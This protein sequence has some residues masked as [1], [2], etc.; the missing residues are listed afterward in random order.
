ASFALA[1]IFPE[2]LASNFG[3]PFDAIPKGHLSK[4]LYTFAEIMPFLIGFLIGVMIGMEI[5]FIA[6][7]REQLYGTHLQHNVG[8]IYGADYIGAGIGAAIFILFMLAIPPQEAALYT[9][10]VN[11]ATGIIFF[12]WHYKSIKFPILLLFTHIMIIGVIILLFIFGTNLHKTLEDTLYSDKVIFSKDTKYQHVTLTKRHASV[13]TMPIYTLFI[14]GRTQFSSDDEHIY[15]DMLVH[16]PIMASAKHDNILIIGGGDGLALRTALEWNP[17]KVTLLE[18]DRQVIELFSTDPQLLQLNSNAFNDPRVT[19]LY[20]DA[21]HTIES[22]IK[23]RQKFDTIIIDLPDPSHPNLN[24]LYSVRFYKKIHDIL[25]GDGA[26][27]IQST[28]PY[29]A[30]RAFLTVGVSMKAAG[31]DHVERYHQN[32]PSFGQ[33]GWTIATK[34]GA[35]AK[36]RI[37]KSEKSLPKNAWATQE[38]ILASFIFSNNFFMIEEHLEPNRLGTH[39]MYLLHQEA[40]MN[41]NKMHKD[42]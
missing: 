31:F 27:S 17:K 5:P 41:D 6:R 14:N 21:F 11:L 30:K 19:V 3:L 2:V 13:D 9:A 26:V 4:M 32:V 1:V 10:F 36:T 15:H 18:L 23:E 25:N 34:F 39:L 33:W 8:T 42:F 40:W 28:S 24:K 37:R 7:I 16:P 29:H 38:L 20:G 22:F 12:I 35:S